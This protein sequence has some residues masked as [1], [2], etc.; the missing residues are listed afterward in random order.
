ML[1]EAPA[2]QIQSCLEELRRDDHDY[3][4]VAVDED[5]TGCESDRDREFT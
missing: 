2:A 1:V 3:T 5:Q 4:G